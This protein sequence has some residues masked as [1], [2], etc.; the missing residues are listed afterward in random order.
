[1]FQLRNLP[2]TGKMDRYLKALRLGGF[3]WNA[4]DGLCA[5]AVREPPGPVASGRPAA[6]LQHVPVDARRF[7]R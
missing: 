2:Q 7:R 1:M 5:G 3:D 6:A 4:F